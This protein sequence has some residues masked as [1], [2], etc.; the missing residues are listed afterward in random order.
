MSSPAQKP[1]VETIDPPVQFEWMTSHELDSEVSIQPE[2]APDSFVAEADVQDLPHSPAK[3]LSQPVSQGGPDD[4]EIG[5]PQPIVYQGE[6]R[7]SRSRKPLW[8]SIGLLAVLTAAVVMFRADL[9]WFGA[10]EVASGEVATPETG[11]S[12]ATSKPA[13]T[14]PGRTEQPAAATGARASDSEGDAGAVT[15]QAA[16]FPNEPAAREF[17]ERLLK[18]GIPAYVLRAEIA[19]RGQWF[20]V[21]VGRFKDRSEATKFAE[22]SRQ[23]GRA[24]GVNLDLVVCNYEEP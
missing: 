19:R 9:P 11:G 14:D 6:S 15:L 20:R 24:A 8:I 4:S 3:E 13:G 21:R 18:H 22:Q 10:T 7:P 1:A 5:S 23:L 2:A 12:Q 16:S 17:A